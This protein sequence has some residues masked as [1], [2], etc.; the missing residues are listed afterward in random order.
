MTEE[1][2]V[3]AYRNFEEAKESVGEFTAEVYNLKRLHSC[4]G[5]LPPLGFETIH[6]LQSEVDLVTD[7]V[8]GVHAKC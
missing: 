8:N 3:K 1:E 4:V 2:Y 7:S 6:A 5:G